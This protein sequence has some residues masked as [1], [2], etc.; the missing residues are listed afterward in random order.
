MPYVYRRPRDSRRYLFHIQWRPTLAGAVVTSPA[1]RIRSL[2][3]Q[4][5]ALTSTVT[6]AHSVRSRITQI[7]SL[8]SRVGG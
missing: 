7:E 1:I 3:T 8:I 5:E 4:S 2:I 6:Q